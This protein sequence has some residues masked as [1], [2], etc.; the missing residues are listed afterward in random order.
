MQNKIFKFIPTSL[1][2]TSIILQGCTSLKPYYDKSQ[3]NW[4]TANAPDTLK[5]KYSIFLIG[6]AGNPDKNRQ[7]P[8]LK[9]LQSQINHSDT[10]SHG[11]NK[12]TVFVNNSHK[13]DVVIFMGDNIYETGLP[14][15]GALDRADKEREITEQMKVV[16]DFKGHKIFVPGNHDWNESRPGGL[17][18]LNRQEEFVETYLNAGD[19]FMPSNGCAG[20]VELQ[21]NNDLVVIIIDSEWWLSKFEKPLAPDNDC[22]S[23]S[24]LDVIQQV[25]DIITRN[26]GKNIVLAE[27]HPLF[28]NGRHGGYYTLKDYL[29]P[30]T[31]IRDNYYLPLPIIGSIY[32]LLRQYG[33]SRQDLANKDYQQLKRGLLSVLENE[34]NVVI[35]A[36]HEHALQLNKYK[37]LNHI[38]SGAGSKSTSLAPGNGA[39]FA[40]GGG[41]VKGFARLNYY[42]NGQCWVEFWQPD[43]D[44]SK[45]KLL[46]RTPL[47]A[48]PPKGKQKIDEQIISYKDSTKTLAASGEYD[49]GQF[50]RS[51]FGEH[52]RQTWATPVKV[53]Y[54]DM[55]IF[56]GGLTPV[57]LG[58]GHQTTSL[59]LQGKD[60]HTYT[61]R[62]IDKDPSSKLPEGFLKTFAEDF[63]QDQ[64]SSSHPYAALIIPP[65]AKSIGIYHTDPQ[66]VYMPFTTSLGPYIQQIGGKLGIVE[67]KPDENLSDF[68]SF[69]NVKK[70]VSTE[71]MYEQI[72]KDND[73]EV[74]QPMFLKA[75]LFD[76]LIGDWDRHEDQWR[77]A[78]FKKDKGTLYRPIPRD[79]DQAFTKF[80][81]F[82]PRLISKF[83][84]HDIQSF[85]LK[86]KDPA[87]LSI[88]ARNLDRNLLNKLS[89]KDWEKIS[90]EIQTAL[91]DEVIE[92]AV[93]K[94]PSEVYAISGK[95][96]S[97]K[98]KS[99]RNQLLEVTNQYYSV[100][101]KEVRVAGSDK[102]EFFKIVRS[103]ETTLLSIYKIDK[104]NKID[105][106]IYERIFNNSETRELNLFALNGQDSVLIEGS[107]ANAIKI[108]I[109]GGEGNDA[110]IDKSDGRTIVYDNN[111]EK[112][113]IIQGK[114]TALRLSNKGYINDYKVN[115]F[116][117]SKSGKTVSLDYDSDDG[118]FIGGG[119]TTKHYGFRKEPYSYD[120]TLIGRYAPKTG[121]Y[122]IKYKA[123]FYS[124][125]GKN[126]DLVLHAAYNNPQHTFN[127]YGQGN[128]TTNIDDL[129]SFYRIRT[130]NIS[131]SAYLQRRFTDAFK[132]GIGPGYE[133]YR[134][135]QSADRYVSTANFPDK[136]DIENPSQ[137]VTL[138][139]Y[140][141]I[142]F[143]ND[144]LF[145]TTGVRWKNEAAF[146]NEMGN[147][148]DRFLKLQSDLSFYATPNINFPITAAVRIGAAANIGDYKFFQAN[149]LGNNTNL[150]GYRNNRFSGR[151]Y[152]Y[153][154]SE[155]RFK[156]ANFRNYIFTGNLGLFGFFDAGRVYSDNPESNTWHTGSGPGFWLNLYNKF[157]FSGAYGFSKEGKYITLKTGFSF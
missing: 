120:Q 119:F 40:Y 92:N 46:Y 67:A 156:V 147:T 88:A 155:L 4:Q 53:K 14:E 61:F 112:N 153:Q 58:G 1:I 135:E 2:I 114:N 111:T 115:D 113:T 9:L 134:V 48:I 132:V 133:Y 55:S 90:V 157:L 86:I 116:T 63:V 35:A 143:V 129:N 125:F 31:L 73:N 96:I 121:A 122:I 23:A 139:S 50:K 104:D 83:I 85:E 126:T 101:A 60:D 79:R 110:I 49:A 72:R 42:D 20:P 76:I 140:A 117:Y 10:S 29:F 32:P 69:G 54:L 78:E 39:L 12:D 43:G 144:P 93:H 107:S 37:D 105:N 145:P 56:A 108:R 30:L 62:L 97:D 141:N 75:R 123:N 13:E 138:R 7:E 106:E 81:G 70:A 109:V 51:L 24:R 136:A 150:R 94:M 89:R 130:K 71:K 82:I 11:L 17:A 124:L 64:I 41:G 98:L 47:Y 68:K 36:G 148:T 28:S 95:E 149:S 102:K 127:Y 33:V 16:K 77:W 66:L 8:V 27:H 131:A 25:Q 65:M 26:R 6:D 137:F 45:G 15:P 18:A 80:D 34:K 99:R 128:S 103:D 142:D 151:S 100:L 84:L 21:L 152:L 22:T 57:K 59:E 74:D 52:Y 38:I 5:L 44:G 87:L 118:A 19:V 154:N 91:S 3:K 146:F